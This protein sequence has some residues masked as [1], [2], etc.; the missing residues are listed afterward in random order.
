MIY[1]DGDGDNYA[2]YDDCGSDDQEVHD[3]DGFIAF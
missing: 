1:N 2:N 3:G